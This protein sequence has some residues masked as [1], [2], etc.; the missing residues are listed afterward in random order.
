MRPD[1]TI[2]KQKN[3]AALLMVLCIGAL[4]IGLSAALAYAAAQ[5]S[6]ST[7]VGYERQ[8]CYLLTSSLCE[9]LGAELKRP[10][11]T[12]CTEED[13]SGA[14]KPD[15]L[16]AFLNGD[17]LYGMY[18]TPEGPAERYEQDTA[19]TFRQQSGAGTDGSYTI[20]TQKKL[21]DEG[22]KKW[23]LEVQY[24]R[25]DEATRAHLKAQYI[26]DYYDKNKIDE[27][28]PPATEAAETYAEMK[29]QVEELQNTISELITLLADPNGLKPLETPLQDYA[30]SISVQGT[31]EKEQFVY[32]KTYV[33]EGKFP[34][35][36][37]IDNQA[38]VFD[39]ETVKEDSTVIRLKPLNGSGQPI[40]WSDPG[41]QQT[42]MFRYDL[43]SQDWSKQDEVHFIEMGDV[44]VETVQEQQQQ[45]DP[46]AG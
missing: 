24:K 14:L 7:Q 43:R 8:Q 27:G 17:Y 10:A 44:A 20:T 41:Q 11:Y 33:H 19:H 15:T 37:M 12:L 30:V 6:A 36:T 3:G 31:F 28:N 29:I 4:F 13:S 5:L 34:K 40:N 21:L 9:T 1:P 2:L 16:A 42:L 26:E 45:A 22:P 46:Q 18:E 25:Y 35:V 38:Y 32:G 23:E 39:L